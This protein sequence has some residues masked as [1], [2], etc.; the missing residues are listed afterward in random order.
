MA[1]MATFRSDGFTP[2]QLV[3]GNAHLLFSE[4]I[5]LVSGQNLTRGAVLGKITASGKYT[6]SASAAVDGSQ[7]PVA[8]LVDD[9]DASAG[10]KVTLVYT[11]GDFQDAGLTLGAGHTLTSIAAALKDAGIFIHLTQGGA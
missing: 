7:T 2:D 1:F 4:Q 6:L 10:D 11:R 3:A 5:T 9:C 8:I